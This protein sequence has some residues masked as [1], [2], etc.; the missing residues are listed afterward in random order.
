MTSSLGIDILLLDY[1]AHKGFVVPY[2]F[3]DVT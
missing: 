2:N 1:S 3:H